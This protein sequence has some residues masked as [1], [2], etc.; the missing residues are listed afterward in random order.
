MGGEESA[1]LERA[2]GFADYP[3][4]EQL[5]AESLREVAS[6]HGVDFATALLFDRV[7]REPR[8]ASFIARINQLQNVAWSKHSDDRTV[9]AIIPAAFHREKPHSDANGRVVREAATQLGLRSE[10]IPTNSTGGCFENSRMILRWLAEHDGERIILVSL[11]K[12]GA[13]VKMALHLADADFRFN[14][15]SAWV[16]VCGTLNGSPVAQWLLRNKS[17]F[18]ATWLFFKC[19]RLNMDCLRDLVPSPQNP[20][21]APLRIPAGMKFISV[22]GFPLRRHLTNAFMRRCHKFISPQG[23]NDGGVLLSDVCRLPGAIYPV[24]GADHYLRPAARSQKIIGAILN[25]LMEDNIR[26]ARGPMNG[27]PANGQI[28]QTTLV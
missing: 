17:R 3:T 2:N 1:L 22:A 8:H 16:N 13:D 11:C 28:A 18:L 5:S 21:N 4:L 25:S 23:P 15:V 24:W 20:L 9:V 7:S 10:M 26:S 27:I 6:R 19:H 14:N 12:G